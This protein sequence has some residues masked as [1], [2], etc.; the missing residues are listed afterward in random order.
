[1]S[2][3]W[4]IDPSA[5]GFSIRYTAGLWDC[6]GL[7]YWD[8]HRWCGRYAVKHSTDATAA[9]IDPSSSCA[10][11]VDVGDAMAE[12]ERL[13]DEGCEKLNGGAPCGT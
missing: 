13:L 7:V 2:R 12:I 11:C 8:G 1:M 3:Q 6:W 9:F 4:Q 5:G 10:P